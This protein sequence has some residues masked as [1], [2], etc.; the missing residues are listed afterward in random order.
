MPRF[1]AEVRELIAALDAPAELI[2]Y[3]HLG[4]GNVHVN[5]LGPDADDA[6]VDVAVLELVAR[7]GGSISA[8]HGVGVA[9]REYLHLSRP[10]RDRS[11]VAPQ[12]RARSRRHPQSGLRASVRPL[13]DP[14]R[15]R[16]LMRA[17]RG[18]GG[19]SGPRPLRRSTSAAATGRSPPRRSAGLRAARPARTN[20]VRFPHDGGHFFF[21][22][23]PCR[24]TS[25][26]TAAAAGGGDAAAVERCG[27]R[28][29]GVSPA[30]CVPRRSARVHFSD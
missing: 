6:R 2:V 30:A 17:P 14:A 5:V 11:D 26:E 27:C 24:Q 8:E 3:G 10:R 15:D 13:G 4:D 22:P 9:K 21:H 20:S 18:G 1:V 7:Y 29:R 28:S 25:P 19:R 16:R 12:G 23:R